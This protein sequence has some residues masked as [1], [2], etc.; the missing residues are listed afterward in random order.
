VTELDA[1]A[2]SVTSTATARAVA[3][4]LGGQLVSGTAVA[5][6]TAAVSPVMALTGSSPVAVVLVAILLLTLGAGL[7]VG[8]RRQAAQI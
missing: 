6:I 4:A 2:G 5:T 8:A 3:P 1:G 7:L